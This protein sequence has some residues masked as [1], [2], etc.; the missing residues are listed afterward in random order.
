MGRLS[1]DLGTQKEHEARNFVANQG[2]QT[3]AQN[4][5]CPGGEIDLI[6]EEFHSKT[7][8]FN[9]FLF[10]KTPFPTTPPVLIFFEI[11]FRATHNFGA[12]LEM[13]SNAQQKRIRKCAE[14]FLLKHEKY[15][16]HDMRFDVLAYTGDDPEPE[17]IQN[18]F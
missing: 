3:V 14:H 7:A 16:N 4:F 9:S 17:W 8:F 6:G 1:K 2:I 15:S 11:K 5:R 13:L 18:A 10:K 12:T